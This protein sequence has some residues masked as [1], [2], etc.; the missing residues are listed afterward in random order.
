MPRR[1]KATGNQDDKQR[2]AQEDLNGATREKLV[3]DLRMQGYDFDTIAQM[4]GYSNRSGAWKAWQRAI[5]RVP[6]ASAELERRQESLRLD[7][8]LAVYW[9]KAIGG[10]G[11]S[12]DRILRNM[13]RRAALLGLDLKANDT[14]AAGQTIIREYGAEVSLT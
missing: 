6:M 4:A 11:W 12:Y 7:S 10:D 14:V 9:P 5:A 1:H 8:L 2:D 3:L 13:E